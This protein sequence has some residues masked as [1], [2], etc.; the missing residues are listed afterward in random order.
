MRVCLGAHQRAPNKLWSLCKRELMESPT[1]IHIYTHTVLDRFVL[2]FL[3][4]LPNHVYFYKLHTVRQACEGP[5]AAVLGPV[6]GDLG[7]CYPHARDGG[8]PVGPLGAALRSLLPAALPWALLVAA[9]VIRSAGACE[10]MPLVAAALAA[11][12][13]GFV[14]AVRPFTGHSHNAF[15]ALWSVVASGLLLWLWI[16]FGEGEWGPLAAGAS[17]ADAFSP[18]ER[19]AVTCLGALLSC[20]YPFVLA[21]ALRVG[22]PRVV[23]TE[24]CLPPAE[25]ALP[26]VL[27]TPPAVSSQLIL[28]AMADLSEPTSTETGRT[29]DNMPPCPASSMR[30][31]TPPSTGGGTCTMQQLPAEALVVT[32]EGAV[33]TPRSEVSLP[34][35]PAVPRDE[36]SA[37]QEEALHHVV[38]IG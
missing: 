23:A 1:H 38:G 10:H 36:D 25:E 5:A 6:L 21:R 24:H 27:A 16:A 22:V 20:R 8:A 19:A 4:A 32:L 15:E 11:L 2:P 3:C 12:Y 33:A 31:R 13:T 18:S 29:A 26:S 35:L 30:V 9:L 37:K 14:A 7:G 34:S 17:W 28:S